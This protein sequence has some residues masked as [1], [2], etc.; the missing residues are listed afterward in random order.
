VRVVVL[1]LAVHAVAF[2]FVMRAPVRERPS[3]PAPSTPIE[4][5]EEEPPPPPIAEPTPIGDHGGGASHVASATRGSARVL[6]GSD[7]PAAIAEEGPAAPA[8]TWSGSFFS[9]GPQQLGIADNPFLPSSPPPPDEKKKPDLGLRFGPSSEGPALA[10]FKDVTSRS[11]APLEGRAQ[12]TVRANADGDVLGI[13]IDSSTGGP[14]WDDA[15]R[16]ALEELRGKRFVVPRGARGI[17][18][19][20]EVVSDVTYPSGQRSK[21]EFGVRDGAVVLPDESNIGQVRTRKIHTRHLGTEV[22]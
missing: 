17:N 12:F 20:F 4:V 16:L 1:S 9:V 21:H 7:E 11:L 10:V 22:L 6:R 5:V 2:A 18:V 14:G 8:P 3:P 13:D 15:K 19:R